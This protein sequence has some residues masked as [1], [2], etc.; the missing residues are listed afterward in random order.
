[1][2]DYNNYKEEYRP[3]TRLNGYYD[4]RNDLK[5]N[6]MVT[7]TSSKV[8]ELKVYAHAD[9][10]ILNNMIMY[11]QIIDSF[12]DYFI[13][14]IEDEPS[15]FIDLNEATFEKGSNPYMLQKN[16]LDLLDDGAYEVC[17]KLYM[18]YLMNLAD[19]DTRKDK[20]IKII[21]VK[22][23][24]GEL[25]YYKVNTKLPKIKRMIKWSSSF[26]IWYDFSGEWANDPGL[27]FDIDDNMNIISLHNNDSSV[28]NYDI[29]TTPERL[30]L[31]KEIMSL[32][33]GDV[34]I[35]YEKNKNKFY[36]LPY[37]FYFDGRTNKIYNSMKSH[38][39]KLLK[40]N[41][42]LMLKTKRKI[43]IGDF[44]KRL[45]KMKKFKPLLDNRKLAEIKSLLLQDDWSDEY[46]KIFKETIF[47]GI[48]KD[49]DRYKIFEKDNRYCV[50]D[51]GGSIKN[52]E[53][54]KALFE[55]YDILD[56]ND[57]RYS[58]KEI[59]LPL[60]EA[61]ENGNFKDDVKIVTPTL[62]AINKELDGDYYGLTMYPQIK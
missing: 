3:G 58:D 25:K 21:Q 57:Y 50:I 27:L 11:N 32:V 47:S 46:V 53:Y 2:I 24:H 5:I 39:E 48:F 28:I 12:N 29:N 43:Y 38:I 56:R 45:I 4:I 1:M 40:E 37:I 44:A 23:R 19:R 36:L 6:T 9:Q 55:A 17:E 10:F 62:D 20:D 7:N 54:A 49:N 41:K 13:N 35:I 30:Y 34:Y 61:D 51:T 33:K 26:M 18:N 60:V 16:I 14:L 52:S 22:T 59:K 42:F 31:S 8:L 15:L